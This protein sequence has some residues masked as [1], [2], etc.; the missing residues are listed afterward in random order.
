MLKVTVDWLKTDGLPVGPGVRN[1]VVEGMR[2]MG[3]RMQKVHEAVLSTHATVLW[4]N[5]VAIGVLEGDRDKRLRQD[6]AAYVNIH[7]TY[8]HDHFTIERT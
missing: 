2:P 5:Y 3:D 4:N 1:D 7:F 8:I 6:M